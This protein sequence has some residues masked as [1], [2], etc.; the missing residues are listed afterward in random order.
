MAYVPWLFIDDVY[1][2]GIL[3]K[4]VNARHVL[5]YGFAYWNFRAAKGC[6]FDNDKIITRT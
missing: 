6:N 2:T 3:A 1:I 5:Q 4:I